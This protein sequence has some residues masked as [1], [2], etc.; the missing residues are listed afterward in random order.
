MATTSAFGWE[1][2]DDTDLVKDGAAAIRTLGN[3]IDTSMAELKGGTTGQVLSKTS[4][5]DMDFTWVA[6]DDANA[7]QNTELTAKGALISAFSAGTP[8][9][10]TVGSNFAFLQADSSTATGLVWNN[11]TWTSW[12]PTVTSSDGAFGS[13]ST[14]FAKYIRVGKMCVVNFQINVTSL[15]T[16]SG[17]FQVTLP[18]NAAAN[19]GDTCVGAVRENNVTG[20]MGQIRIVGNSAPTMM[21]M[22]GYNNVGM[23]AANARF[24][25]T[26]TYE[27][28]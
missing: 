28:A 19:A 24:G 9:T 7:I 22:T 14:I 16:A 23:I 13:T 21:I 10:L 6:Q 4:N 3:S 8:A 15:G 27:V 25:G 17:N 18:F 26:A 1:T 20:N 12:T 5:T 11:A 2:P